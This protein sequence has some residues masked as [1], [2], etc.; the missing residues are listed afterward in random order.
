MVLTY[1]FLLLLF[2][3]PVAVSQFLANFTKVPEEQL[4]AFTVTSPFAAAFSV[5]LP[6]RSDFTSEVVEA[7]KPM[8]RLAG[9]EIPLWAAYLVVNPILAMVIVF[10]TYLMFR[11][12]W[13]SA[14]AAV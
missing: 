1:M 4:T 6:T 8:I 7:A 3:A 5:P 9:Q 10:L 2:A 11:W 12:R 14:A 13:W